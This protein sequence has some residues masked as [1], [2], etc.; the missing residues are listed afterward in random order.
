[1]SFLRSSIPHFA[2]DDHVNTFFTVALGVEFIDDI[3]KMKPSRKSMASSHGRHLREAIEYFL[4][5]RP[6]N[7]I[8]WASL[9]HV[10]FLDD[11]H[12]YA[13]LQD[14][15]DYFYGDRKKP[16]VAPDPEAP[17]PDWVQERWGPGR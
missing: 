4:R 17:M 6:C 12:L 16:P 2:T 15:H 7:V 1:M 3:D 10:A 9:T 5:E 14:L 8:E 13:Y 11:A